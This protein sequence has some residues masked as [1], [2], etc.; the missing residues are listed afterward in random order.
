M[1][2][3]A[4]DHGVTALVNVF[5]ELEHVPEMAELLKSGKMTGKAV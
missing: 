3:V 4:V 1:Y 2:K 5:N